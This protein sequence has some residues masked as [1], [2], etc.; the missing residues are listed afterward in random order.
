[1]TN[2]EE[3]L[4]AVLAE[5]SDAEFTSQ[6]DLQEAMNY[7]NAE[8]RGDEIP[9][10]S[11]VQSHDVA[12]MI[13][14]LA[15]QIM[16]AFD[17]ME[18]ASFEALNEADEEQVRIES[19]F[20]NHIV[21]QVNNGFITIQ[22]AL[23][24]ALLMRNCVFK[25]YVETNVD[26]KPIGIADDFSDIEFMLF[27]EG[28]ED[29]QEL[30]IDND[31]S[32]TEGEQIVGTITTRHEL[33]V[34]SIPPEEFLYSKGWN[35]QSL[36]D[37]PFTAHNRELKRYEL[38]D[39]GHDPDIVAKLSPS[40]SDYAYSQDIRHTESG[41]DLQS[42]ANNSMLDTINYYE[43][44]YIYDYNGDGYPELLKICIAS[45]ELLHVETV[46]FHAFA[47]GNTVLMPNRFKGI[48]THDQQK[49]VQDGKTKILRQY[50][51]NINANNNRRLEVEI[52]QVID[53]NDLTDSKPGGII[54]TR[55][56]GSIAPIP[57]DDIGPSCERFL[58]YWDRI[59]TNRSGASLDMVSENM[60][61]GGETAH[62]AERIISSKEQ[63]GALAANTFKE[64]AVK[65]MFMLVHK[66]L[67]SFIEGNKSAKIN[68]EWLETNP[69][70]WGERTNVSIQI[71]ASQGMSIK[72]VQALTNVV[73][74]QIK[75]F[76]SGQSGILVN[77]DKVYNALIDLDR[78]SGI[79]SPEK[80]WM[81]PK[82]QASQ[83]AIQANQKAS[84][85]QR[86]LQ[87][88]L[89]TSMLKNE[90]LRV[91]S[92]MQSKQSKAVI[93]QMKLQ[94]DNLKKMAS[95]HEKAVDVEVDLLKHYDNMAMQ[96]TSL[97]AQ[98]QS[99]IEDFDQNRDE[100]SE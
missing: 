31:E 35:K 30:Y 81:N 67:R 43:A 63:I 47:G 52:K 99:Q 37:C 70:L 15:S 41:Q 27:R 59:R 45:D 98:Y 9:G 49:D 20:V 39:M 29:N 33:K 1:M 13:E 21:M 74:R 18:I 55:K 73:D 64:T 11:A 48:S 22:E 51:D 25:V 69:Q 56:I 53:P 24:T 78:A 92:D 14:A 28:L 61:V 12:D 3:L 65:D 60:P 75:A 32:K 89:Q 87:E 54:K 8:L 71:G 85:E 77:H 40:T 44:Y 94:L 97:E 17:S 91:Q 93:D 90:S 58:S 95:D 84:E 68:G 16:P 26:V 5:I 57:V 23:K 72:K 86:K 50:T 83:A 2:D 38:I 62:G 4:A 10:R 79:D 42:T 76:N 19:K 6:D 82:S 34:E 100:T 88:Q 80:Y 96:L 7:Y 36:T 66:T 46:D